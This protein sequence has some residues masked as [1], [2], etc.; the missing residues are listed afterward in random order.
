MEEHGFC[1]NEVTYNILVRGFLC[2]NDVT[3]ALQLIDVMTGRGFSPDA[4]NTSSL[5]DLLSNEQ[6]EKS[7][8][9]W[10]RS[11]LKH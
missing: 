6:T 8:K 1:P 10:L 9:E 3:Q 2:N 5:L 4:D 7:V 11:N